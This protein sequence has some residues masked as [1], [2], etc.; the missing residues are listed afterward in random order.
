MVSTIE[1]LIIHPILFKF[2]KQYTLLTI[3]FKQYICCCWKRKCPFE[4][5][6]Q[7]NFRQKTEYILFLNIKIITENETIVCCIN[8]YRF[9]TL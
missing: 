2:K 4:I 3:F 7:Q 1:T 8:I 6:V 5:C 9:N